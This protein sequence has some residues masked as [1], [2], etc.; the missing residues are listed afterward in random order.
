M[1]RTLRPTKGIKANGKN[2]AVAAGI[3]ERPAWGLGP[4]FR[5]KRKLQDGGSKER[6]ESTEE[7]RNEKAREGRRR[8]EEMIREGK[9]EN[10]VGNRAG[11]KGFVILLCK[12]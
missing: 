9:L 1:G 7:V 5:R 6:R 11:K 4:R 3:C 8:R 10:L 2:V 12:R